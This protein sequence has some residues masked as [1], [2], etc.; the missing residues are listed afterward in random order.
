MSN[1][2]RIATRTS[3]LAMA[4]TRMVADALKT[5]HP[6]LDLQIVSVSTQGDQDR[7][8]PL[9]QLSG[10]GFF[11]SQLEQALLE[12]RADIAV[13]SCKDLP[14]QIAPGLMIG[15]VP[16]R[17]HAEDVLIASEPVDS[18]AGLKPNAVVGSSSPRRIAQLRHFRPDVQVQPLRG[19]VE[20]R[21]GK[22]KDGSFDAIVLARAGLAR[23]NLVPEA[24][25]VFDPVEFVPAPAQGA[26]A[27]QCRRGD[28]EIVTLLA[29][30]HHEATGIVVGVERTILAALHPG[31]HAPVGVYARL[32]GQNLHITALVAD[33]DGQTYIK[34]TAEGLSE[35]S[36]QVVQTLL[37]KLLDA[38][39]QDV[40]RRFE[41]A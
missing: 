18:L 11:T 40:I 41:S 28:T 5:Y 10:S 34:E 37:Q 24:S 36:G 13:H 9:W 19:N 14:V 17:R 6:E 32:L 30:L 8:S 23:L 7:I 20:T 26:L 33:L 25:F 21:L 1:N 35:S 31:C 4:Q 12:D 3:A 2:L 22:V 16:E 39:A 38:G 29:D 15:A 27:V